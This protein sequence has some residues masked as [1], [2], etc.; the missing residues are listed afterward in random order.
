L[1]INSPMILLTSTSKTVLIVSYYFPPTGMG[2]VQRAAKFVKYLPHYGWNPVV[3]TVRDIAYYNKDEVLLEDIKNAE[4]HRTNSFDP[5]RVAHVLNPGRKTKGIEKRDSA[6]IL[7]KLSAWLCIPDNKNLWLPFALSKA[8]SLCKNKNIDLVFTTGPPFSSFFTGLYLKKTLRMPL[9]TDFRD[10]WTKGEFYNAPTAIHDK[11][12]KFLEETVVKNSDAVCGVS[13][14]IIEQIRH[15]DMNKYRVIMNGFDEEDFPGTIKYGNNKFIITYAGTVLTITH[16]EVFAHVLNYAFENRPGMKNDY[17]I[18]F[19]GFIDKENIIN[20]FKKHGIPEE[21][22]IFSGYLYH[23]DYINRILQSHILLF[24]ISEGCS[25][26]VITGRIFELLA[27][28]V[29]LL[30]VVP[31]CEVRDLILKIKGENV[32]SHN[33]LKQASEIIV[34][35]YD[36][37]IHNKGKTGSGKIEFT[38]DLLAVS[39]RKLTEKLAEIFDKVVDDK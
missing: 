5:L 37:W 4:I 30:A 10:G 34:K 24:T 26:G 27:S 25:K 19:T 1:N 14:E 9:I 35:E 38:T 17:E 18:H 8:Y 7:R 31:E 11:I 23:K 6:D 15:D 16:P 20:I 28:G 3:L 22:L 36:G 33:E 39:R 29:P 12:N 32:F 2:G 21:K 13:E